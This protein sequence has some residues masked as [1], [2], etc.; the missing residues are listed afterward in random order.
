[1]NALLECR[2]LT[3]SYGRK[4]ALSNVDLTI[5]PGRIVGLL[6]PN[7]S[8]KS[9]LIKLANGLL[10]PTAGEILV[11]GKKPGVESHLSVS[12]LPDKNY[13]NDWMRFL[14]EF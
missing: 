14:S 9:T 11:C 8:G 2:N 5:S 6:G 13:L 12:Y 3:K 4:P 1:M 10:T 7:G